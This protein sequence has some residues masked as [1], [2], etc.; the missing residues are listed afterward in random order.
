MSDTQQVAVLGAGILGAAM[1]RSL[2]REG[3]EVRLWNR[4]PAKA[5]AAAAERIAPAGSVAE[6]VTGA[7]AVVTVLFDADSVLAVTDELVGAL[8]PHAVWVQA[9]TVG[10][11]G[12]RRIEQAAGEAAARLVDAPVLGT[13]KP[14]ED[15]QLVVL[16]S[17]PAAGRAAARPVFEAIGSRVVDVGDDLGS[18]S[19][20]KLVCNSW[21]A[22]MNAGIGQGIAFAGALGLDPAL[23]LE[24]VRGGAVDAPYVQVKGGLMVER[25]W[26]EPSFAVDGVRKDLGLML[27]AAQ[28][29]SLA[30]DLLRTLLDHYDRTSGAGEGGSDMAAVRVAFD[31]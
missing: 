28:D 1:A 20:L 7:D 15:G 27:E 17:G 13:R 26:A 23:F 11:D 9:S 5:Q 4:T 6:A 2:A 12:M 18:A 29:T 19:A 16:A 14:A 25:A 3:H 21:V 30:T 10:P 24:A 31:R 8:G 22:T